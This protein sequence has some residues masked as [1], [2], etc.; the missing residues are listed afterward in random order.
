MIGKVEIPNFVSMCA[1]YP[2]EENFVNNI[3]TM[4]LDLAS[5]TRHAND[6]SWF[7]LTSEE[8]QDWFTTKKPM[9]EIVK[10]YR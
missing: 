8:Y 1:S 7:G 10:A 5:L 3:L 4:Y 6:A 9:V 2:D